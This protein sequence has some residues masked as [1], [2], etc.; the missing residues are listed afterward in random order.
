MNTEAKL[1]RQEHTRNYI[2]S[3]AQPFLN[4]DKAFDINAFT[5]AHNYYASKIPYY[6]G[7][8]P[9]F[10]ELLGAKTTLRSFKYVQKIKGN[11]TKA[12]VK[13]VR[14][15]LAL[16]RLEELQESGMSMSDIAT[17]YGVSRQAIHQLI[18]TLDVKD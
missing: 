7:S 14:N 4:E 18:E 8:K 16:E 11:I 1:A 12:K 9:K 13:T 15:M 17:M 6:F 10:Y 2:L 5:K 3:L